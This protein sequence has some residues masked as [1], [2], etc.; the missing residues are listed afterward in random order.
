MRLYL[1]N[2]QHKKKKNQH[3]FCFLPSID[4]LM[5]SGKPSCPLVCSQAGREWK[6]L[7]F[8]VPY[9]LLGSHMAHL[10]SQEPTCQ[11]GK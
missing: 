6:S 7:R 2:T 4:L 5:T 10:F 11:M 3:C 8:H 1:K 9:S